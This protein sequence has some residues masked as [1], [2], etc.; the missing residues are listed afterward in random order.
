MNIYVKRGGKF[1]MDQTLII[2]NIQTGGHAYNG[3]HCERG[4]IEC[5]N[6]MLVWMMYLNDCEDGGETSFLYQK[7]N[8]KPEKGL[9]LFWLQILHIHTEECLVIKQKKK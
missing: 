9:L 6:R 7:Y 2:K 1:K 8:M 4:G 5:T 3:W